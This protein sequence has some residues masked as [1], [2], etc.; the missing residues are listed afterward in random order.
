MRMQGYTYVECINLLG[1][2]KTKR[3]SKN[4]TINI[5]NED[6]NIIHVSLHDSAII[7]LY[8]NGDVII[9][10]KGFK[11]LTTKRIINQFLKAN[12]IDQR[13][14]Q[15]NGKWFICNNELH[16]LC[17]FNDVFRFQSKI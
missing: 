15:K 9:S 6:I 12:K 10:D 16:S 5:Y 3:L 7:L 17:E 4:T 11:T 1:N 13:V 14:Y 8:S 2:K